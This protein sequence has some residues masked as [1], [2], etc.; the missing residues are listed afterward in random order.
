MEILLV[1][2]EPSVRLALGDALKGAGHQV[3]VAA[4]GAEAL[5]AVG[6]KTFDLVITDIRLPKADGLAIF[7]RVREE[8]PTTDVILITAHG[9]VS[10]AVAA[11]KEGATDYMLK[12]FETDQL[13]HRVE[14]LAATRALHRELEQARAALAIKGGA[15]ARIVGVS[16]QMRRLFERIETF[17][18]SD[19]PVLITG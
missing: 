6:E 3:R 19:A 13:L 10:D 7:H 4:D 9:S 11:L 17:A 5:A 15:A 2:D 1:D 14:R 8:S 12:P 16:P 18:A